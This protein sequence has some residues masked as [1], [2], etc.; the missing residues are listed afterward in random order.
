MTQLSRAL[1]LAGVSA[2]AV[3]ASAGSAAASP[4]PQIVP[5]VAGSTEAA[6]DPALDLQLDPL[7]GTGSDPLANGVRTQVA[8]FPALGTD[9]VTGPLTRGASARELPGEVIG[10]LLGGLPVTFPA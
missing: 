7:A 6:L 9:V 5:I 4:V 2:G 1:G 10:G 3:L 8:D